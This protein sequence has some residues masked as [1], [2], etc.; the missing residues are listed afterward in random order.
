MRASPPLA[1]RAA[2]CGSPRRRRCRARPGASRVRSR[3]SPGRRCPHHRRPRRVLGRHVVARGAADDVV[4]AQV[5]GADALHGVA[6]VVEVAVTAPVGRPGE[7]GR[8]LRAVGGGEGV[9]AQREVAQRAR[10]VGLAG[11][12]QG[13]LASA[14]WSPGRPA[15]R[16]PGGP[17]GPARPASR[18][19]PGPAVQAAPAAPGA[20]APRGGRPGGLRR[21]CRAGPGRTGRP[22]GAGRTGDEGARRALQWV[23][24]SGCP[25]RLSRV[26]DT[27]AGPPSV[28]EDGPARVSRVGAPRARRCAGRR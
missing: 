2:A 24:G 21:P 25:S 3:R 19:R 28:G 10:E 9:H 6:L 15:S 26:A 12:R 27:H 16:P 13:L 14:G 4:H 17:R 23:E 20:R 8:G 7:V 1:R 18:S 5:V 22:R 11:L